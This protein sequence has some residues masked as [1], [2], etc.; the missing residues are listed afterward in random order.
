MTLQKVSKYLPKFL[1]IFHDENI[2]NKEEVLSV[3]T[4][5]AS[6]DD[7]R[8]II[9]ENNVT[10]EVLEML[11]DGSIDACDFVVAMSINLNFFT[12]ILEL[13]VYEIILNCFMDE[14]K[15]WMD[16]EIWLGAFLNLINVKG[17]SIKA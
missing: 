1:E 11:A 10:Q 5:F 3:L 8:R 17:E 4:E 16:R 14:E 7:N 13:R 6:F 2:S 15:C 12:E 9:Y